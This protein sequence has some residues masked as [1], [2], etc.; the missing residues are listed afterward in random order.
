L[1]EE[2][3]AAHP[4]NPKNSWVGWDAKS[5]SNYWT[6]LPPSNVLSA[7]SYF[8]VALALKGVLNQKVTVM[9]ANHHKTINNNSNDGFGFFKPQDYLTVL[10]KS[11][12]REA[13][14][15]GSYTQFPYS[16][17]LLN[18]K[19]N[20]MLYANA[21]HY[22]GPIRSLDYAKNYTSNVHKVIGIES[23]NPSLKYH[24]QSDGSIE[25]ANWL[26][27]QS[28]T[29]IIHGAKGV[30][31]WDLSQTYKD[32][33]KSQLLISN[34]A[35]TSNQIIAQV[36]AAFSYA[37]TGINDA[38]IN[39]SSDLLVKKTSTDT[40]FVKI[41]ELYNNVVD[42]LFNSRPNK[43]SRQNFSSNYRNYISYLGKELGYLV[44]KNLISTD[45]NTI[46]YSKTD[47]ADNN[48]I[49]PAATG[50]SYI[51]T[52]LT[53]TYGSAWVSANTAVVNEKC[54]ENYGL[55]YTI[56][57]N[58]NEVIMIV[59]NPM[60]IPVTVPLSFASL[61]N[62][63]IKN[64]TGVNVLFETAPFNLATA[65][66]Y[67]T[68]RNS[69]VDLISNINPQQYYIPY[70]GNKQ[71]TLTFGPMD[72]HVLRFA[73]NK[74]EYNNSWTQVWSNAGNGQM[75]G[76]AIGGQD[77]L[78]PGDFDGD[79]VEELLVVQNT[80][81]S[82]DWMTIL[83]Y[84]NGDWTWYWSN[85]GNS[86]IG[87][88]IYSYRSKLI[89]GDFDGD[90]KDEVLGN[91]T[92][93][94]MFKFTNNNWQLFWSDGGTT[95]SEVT[96]YYKTRMMAGDFIPGDGGRK[97][98]VGFG[99]DRIAMLQYSNGHF[100]LIG[101]DLNDPN[102]PLRPYRTSP[103]Y[104]GDYNG[105]G[106]DDLIAMASWATVF[107]YSVTNKR[108]VWG[109][110][111]TSGGN[112]LGGLTYPIPASDKVLVGNLDADPK[113]ELFVLQTG[114]QA[115]WATTLDINLSVNPSSWNWNFS[116]N[117]NYGVPFVDDWPLADNGGSDTRYLLLKPVI[118]KPKHLLA[119]RKYSCNSTSKYLVS[120]Y[121]PLSGPN[122][123][124][125]EFIN[126]D[127]AGKELEEKQISIYPNPTSN[128]M[129]VSLRNFN[130]NEVVKADLYDNTGRLIQN[131][132][133]VISSSELYNYKIDL[134]NFPSGVYL[135]KVTGNDFNSNHQL[136]KIN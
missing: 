126:N 26:W 90:G 3:S 37:L 78:Y 92:S 31:F 123:K 52:A 103:I 66:T 88:G 71:I 108:W 19:Y 106:K 46:I 7:L 80:G 5:P 47:A 132:Q 11:D 22:L 27:F 18:Q 39:C 25:N 8:K 119:M 30:W 70:S 9:E 120:M 77:I 64:S 115:S 69:G 14:F 116:A 118:G 62:P 24:F 97:E 28:Y 44:K 4:F 107:E 29:S 45:P 82:N 60:N 43:F 1:C 16:D 129:N 79:G 76:V 2:A 59:S 85:Y 99:S 42:G 21:F 98:L 55:R 84:L 56:R 101:S 50:N 121:Q 17:W 124:T 111:S 32:C 105:D 67:K 93:T 10:T 57:T 38:D 104:P 117:P 41:M 13:F 15:E 54:T 73:S 63:Y 49:I 114:P 102:N 122:F 74:P 113:T 125:D 51:K 33:E 58:G 112:S 109:Y 91:S 6:E 94:T 86:T 36:K 100:V 61:G 135:L 34:G 20:D 127:I 87:N 48:C 96:Q 130:V 35:Y 136:V 89:V 23:S 131:Q 128:E 95:A 65:S 81:G 68:N 75:N 40:V 133:I 53:N 83:K 72:V 12:A 134:A 110:Y